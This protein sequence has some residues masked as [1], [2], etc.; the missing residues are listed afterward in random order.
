MGRS[1]ISDKQMNSIFTMHSNGM[2][3]DE[4]SEILEI[5][6]SCVRR[7]IDV[8]K[9]LSSSNFEAVRARFG[10][11]HFHIVSYAA[12]R[13]GISFPELPEETC[14]C[15]RQGSAS[16]V[17]PLDMTNTYL[18]ALLS[19]LKALRTSVDALLCSLS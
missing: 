15:D 19:E 13:L 5:S 17:S 11:K 4:I 10:D 12:N 8:F 18:I 2:C 1:R 14:D 7:V 6:N 16:D 3:V 9:L